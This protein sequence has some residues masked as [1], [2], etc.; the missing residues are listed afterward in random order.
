MPRP[1]QRSGSDRFFADRANVDRRPCRSYGRRYIE[2]AATASVFI[3]WRACAPRWTTYGLVPHAHALL[4][5]VAWPRHAYHSYEH[6]RPHNGGGPP[7]RDDQ[8]PCDGAR[9][10]DG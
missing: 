2:M 5:H 3:L 10:M 9:L 1:R 8:L 4:L 7:Q 6:A